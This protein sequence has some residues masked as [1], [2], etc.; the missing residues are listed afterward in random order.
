MVTPKLA[1]INPLKHRGFPLFSPSILG[2]F[3]IFG[4]TH[5][6]IKQTATQLEWF[7]QVRDL[8]FRGISA[9]G[10]DF[11]PLLGHEKRFRCSCENDAPLRRLRSSIFFNLEVSIHI[12][13]K[14]DANQ[15]CYTPSGN[16]FLEVVELFF[17]TTVATV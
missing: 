5:I 11:R 14:M 9:W 7:D 12:F 16:Y 8:F 2:C 4:N 13:C 1:Q 17:I 6:K 15:K 3:P 10:H